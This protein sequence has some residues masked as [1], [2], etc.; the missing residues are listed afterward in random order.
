MSNLESW[1]R[2]QNQLTILGGLVAKTARLSVLH[3]ALLPW[4]PE[5]MMMVVMMMVMMTKTKKK[6]NHVRNYGT[7]CRIPSLVS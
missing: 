7:A 2:Y 5:Q 3:V 1:S 6:N 4:D